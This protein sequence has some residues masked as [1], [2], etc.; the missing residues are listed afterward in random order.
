MN[1]IT[2]KAYAKINLGLDVLRKR[3]DGYHDVSMIMQTVS[4]YD[5]LTFRKS[6][7]RDITLKTNLPYLPSDQKN[8]VYKA[9]EL[10][11]NTFHISE[12]IHA[13]IYKRIPVAA[14]LAGGSSDAAAALKGLNTLYRTGL[15]LKELMELGVTLGADVPYCLLMGTALSEGIGEILTPLGPMPSC[16]ILLV[17]PD[18][19]VSTKYVYENLVLDHTVPHPDIPSMLKAIE[20][21]D[22]AELIVTMGNILE[23]VTVKEYPVINHIKNDMINNGA[24]TSLMSG[25]GPTVFGIYDNPA[26]AEKAY[27]YFKN[28]SY[29]KQVFLTNPYWPDLPLKQ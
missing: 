24:L 1:S 8:I 2:M 22:L 16:N 10:F 15:T 27:K 13:T 3:E 7:K 12:G 14:G 25:S 21:G 6:R 28:S 29:K 26:T 11:K 5:T 9:I 20:H 23:T 17:K 18:L 4:L 19:N